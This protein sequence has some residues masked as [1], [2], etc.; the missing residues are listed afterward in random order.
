MRSDTVATGV[1]IDVRLA[2][3]NLKAVVQETRGPA[4]KPAGTA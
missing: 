3:G 4:R 2:A 1:Q